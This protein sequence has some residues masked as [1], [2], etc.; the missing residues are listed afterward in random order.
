M[1]D[2]GSAARGV[3]VHQQPDAAGERARHRDLGGVQQGHD[4]PPEFLRCAGREGGIEIAGDG[5][6]GAYDVVRLQLV[7][8]DQGPEQLVGGSKNFA[9]IVVIDG[10]GSANTLQP[11]GGER[12]GA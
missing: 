6:Q 11:G 1:L 9:G 7:G 4:L 12:H 8:F 2:F 3:R 5:E 10:G